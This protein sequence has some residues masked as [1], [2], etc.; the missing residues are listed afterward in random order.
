VT[1]R[2]KR[3]RKVRQ[4]GEIGEGETKRRRE[5]HRQVVKERGRK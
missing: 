5:R 3:E 1:E 2:G 4:D